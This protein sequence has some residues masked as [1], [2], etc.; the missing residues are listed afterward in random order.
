MYAS[1]NKDQYNLDLSIKVEYHPNC[2][3]GEQTHPFPE[4]CK[5]SNPGPY[6]PSFIRPLSVLTVYLL[7]PDL[8]LCF[9]SNFLITSH[10]VRALMSFLIRNQE[11]GHVQPKSD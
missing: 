7:S 8:S 4:L 9:K 3:P 2:S 10:S 6:V 11:P 1:V 5:P